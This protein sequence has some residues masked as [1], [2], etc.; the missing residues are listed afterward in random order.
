MSRRKIP[1]FAVSLFSPSSSPTAPRSSSS[2]ARTSAS[3]S[4][5]TRSSSPEAEE[6]LLSSK[7]ARHGYDSLSDDNL[8][9][10]ASDEDDDDDLSDEI[11][12]EDEAGNAAMPSKKRR[13]A[14]PAASAPVP[15]AVRKWAHNFALSPRARSLLEQRF[16]IAIKLEPTSVPSSAEVFDWACSLSACDRSGD[17]NERLSNL[18]GKVDE[19]ATLL[20]DIREKVDKARHRLTKADARE[21][22]KA[23]AFVFFSE[24]ITQYSAG[25]NIFDRTMKY[26]KACP[27]SVGSHFQTLLDDREV[28]HDEIK[29]KVRELL[30]RLRDMCATRIHKSMGLDA[31]TKGREMD[32][33]KLWNHVCSGYGV[34]FTKK[35]AMRLIHI[36]SIATKYP[37]RHVDGNPVGNFWETVDSTL[38]QFRVLQKKDPNQEQQNLQRLWTEDQ[39]RYGEFHDRHLAKPDERKEEALVNALG[40]R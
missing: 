4:R 29:P 11:E 14:A 19:L 13:K 33:Q 18:E 1:S 6:S 22:G 39:K 23:V 12:D 30:N 5:A 15:P 36:R 27:E 8:Y 25:S 7:P 31:E 26:L 37:P 24:Q 28:Y 3:L 2:A 20:D 38:E 40:A 9:H 16:Q 35:R 17:V 21:L 10:R 32:G 34:P